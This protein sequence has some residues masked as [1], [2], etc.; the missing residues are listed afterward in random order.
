MKHL[1]YAFLILFAFSS[2][3]FA[4]SKTITLTDGSQIKGDVLSA[5]DGVYAIKTSFGNIMVSDSDIQSIT[6]HSSMPPSVQ[7]LGQ[8]DPGQLKTQAGQYQQILM[9]DQD[10]MGDM[11][12]LAQDPEIMGLL[13]DP[14]LIKA[15]TSQN[16]QSLQNH[17]NFQKLLENP[18]LRQLLE[19]A[20]Q[21][22]G[23]GTELPSGL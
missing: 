9:Q 1:F 7:N 13:S 22:M 5:Q 23:S 17:P 19:K 10:F 11:Q 15:V 20:G 6:A 14:E 8:M 12:G 2:V 3:C 21:K 18:K 4:E 16:M